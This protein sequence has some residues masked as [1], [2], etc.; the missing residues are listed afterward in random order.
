[1][2]RFLIASLAVVAAFA[3]SAVA[4]D[5]KSGPQ[6]GAK[7][8]GAFS[9][10]NVNGE[11]AG[12]KRCLVC[13]NGANP[14][15]MIFARTAECP[16]AAKLIKKVDEVTAK[17]S[18]CDMGSFVVFCADDEKLEA[19]LK[20]M[21][22]KAELKKVIL[23]IDTPTGPAKYSIAKDADITVVLY[24]EGK[25]VVNKAFKKGDITDADIDTI[26]A[27]VSKITPTK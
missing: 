4:E 22:T 16:Q 17:N 27:D 20:E 13:K 18:G 6:A 14:V 23:S 7:L 21:V 12:Q 8:P 26:I 25:V 10:L 11:D 3:T 15:A 5:L 1:M 24:N 19:K 2:T 9:P